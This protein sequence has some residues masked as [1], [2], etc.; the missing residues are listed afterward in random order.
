MTS[1]THT[2][3]NMESNEQQQGDSMLCLIQAERTAAAVH[4]L[5]LCINFS[6]DRTPAILLLCARMQLVALTHSCFDVV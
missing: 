6:E 2:N 3:N 1:L 5:K 4:L